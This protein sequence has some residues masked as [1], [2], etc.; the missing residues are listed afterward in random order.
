[1][2]QA[3]STSVAVASGSKKPHALISPPLGVEGGGVRSDGEDLFVAKIHSWTVDDVTQWLKSVHL[4][5]YVS[6]F[7]ENEINGHSIGN[8]PRDLDYMGVKSWD[9]ERSF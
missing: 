5:Q 8:K 1:M 4:S 9:I 6:Q 7:Q 3:G 2:N